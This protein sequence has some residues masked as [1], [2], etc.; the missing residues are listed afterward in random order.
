[1]RIDVEQIGDCTLYC[2]DCRDIL[3]TLGTSGWV[4]VTDPPFGRGM[5]KQA[6][7]SSI[8]DHDQWPAHTWD[9]ARPDAALWQQLLAYPVLAIWGGNYF[10]DV[11]PPSPAWLAWLKPEHG[12]G[13]SLAD[14][15]LCWTNQAFA[16]RCRP[17][18]RRDGHQHPTQKP[19]SVMRWT[20]EWMPAGGILDPFMGV[21]STGVACVRL[22]RRFLGIEIE[23]AY[24]DIACQRLEAEYA[25]PRLFPPQPPQVRSAQASLW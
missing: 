3:P 11:L 12:S 15:E 21:G 20:L 25:Q 7:H 16:A 23:R 24:F 17:F 8:R 2:G 9:D 4:L 10:T 18:P 19:V 1:M 5:A 14:M 13:F 6:A 22:G